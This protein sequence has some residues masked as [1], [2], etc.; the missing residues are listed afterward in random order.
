LIVEFAGLPKSGKTS[1]I[2]TARDY[3][4][5]SGHSVKMV[6]ETVRSCPFSN[7]RRIDI[8]C[9][10]A[11]QALSSVL[12]ARFTTKQETL[13]LQDRGLFDALAFFKLLHLEGL[14]NDEALAD[15]MGYFANP[16]W[17]RFV[18]L[19]ILFDISPITAIERDFAAKLRAGP[20]IITN[21]ATIK[22]LSTAYDFV[23]NQYGSR[24]SRIERLD[25]TDAELIDIAR[26]VMRIIQGSIHI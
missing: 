20:G 6:G 7:Q 8:A 4:L 13:V 1:G 2:E 18:D 5:R 10:T 23:L 25:T 22:N 11:N 12:E 15:F 26:R 16:R 14:I 21:I 3:F 19:V 17:T 9:W 24:F